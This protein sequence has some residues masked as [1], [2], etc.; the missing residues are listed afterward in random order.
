[1]QYVYS[2]KDETS[3]D[4][5]KVNPWFRDLDVLDVLFFHV[6]LPRHIEDFQDHCSL[7]A[8]SCDIRGNGNYVAISIPIKHKIGSEESSYNTFHSEKCNIYIAHIGEA[9][10]NVHRDF[11]DR[12]FEENCK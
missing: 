8:E 6:A 4:I 7:K 2:E 5:Q 10:G 1:M 12:F 3:I 11:I 9:F